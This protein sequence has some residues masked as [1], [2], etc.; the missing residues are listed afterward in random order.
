MELNCSLCLCVNCIELCVK[1]CT[2]EHS[3]QQQRQGGLFFLFVKKGGNNSLKNCQICVKHFRWP[4][5]RI[6]AAERQRDLQT[7]SSISSSSLVQWRFCFSAQSRWKYK[8]IWTFWM[9]VHLIMHRCVRICL[10]GG[11]GGGMEG[12]RSGSCTPVLPSS[13]LLPPPSLSS[14]SLC[15]YYSKPKALLLYFTV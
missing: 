6:A 5:R 3:W 13:T 7:V 10:C 2:H 11:G 9:Y 8:V 1:L 15:I 12:E 14:S 4:P